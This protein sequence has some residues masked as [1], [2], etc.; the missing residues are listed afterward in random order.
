MSVEL[1]FLI[2]V[3]LAIV[4]SI[5]P[6]GIACLGTWLKSKLTQSRKTKTDH[7]V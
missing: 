1:A 3:G 5:G 2:A 4:M 6:E 7:T